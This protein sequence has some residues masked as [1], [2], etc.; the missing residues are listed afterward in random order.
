MQMN[1]VFLLVV[2]LANQAVCQ[3]QFVDPPPWDP[4]D[5]GNRGFSN[6]RRYKDGDDVKIRL[7]MKSYGDYFPEVHVWQVNPANQNRSEHKQVAEDV[8]SK[9]TFW[10]AEYD[11]N[12]YLRHGEDAV[13]R[14]GLLRYG[15]TK[16]TVN[17]TYFNVSM[18][19]N[20]RPNLPSA[21]G[22]TSMVQESPTSQSTTQPGPDSTATEKPSRKN[23]KKGKPSKK[24]GLTGPEV[25]G[26][27]VGACFAFV[28]ILFGSFW[29]FNRMRVSRQLQKS[30]EFELRNMERE[31]RALKDTVSRIGA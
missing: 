17:S 24:S 10:K 22:T 20:W 27:T 30:H 18:P 1:W 3:T 23:R 11:V 15:Q 5:D 14:F 4:E 6:N 16:S 12:R 29:G 21:S 13:Y 7:H 2:S 25:V 28:L 31:V 19:D 26:I 9:T 8:H